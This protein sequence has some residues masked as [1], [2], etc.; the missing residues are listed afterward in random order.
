VN[1]MSLDIFIILGFVDRRVCKNV[2]LLL[3]MIN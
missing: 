1:I 2:N 3:K